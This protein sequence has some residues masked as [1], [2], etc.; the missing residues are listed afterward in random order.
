MRLI[1]I[2][3]SPAILLVW[4][5]YVRGRPSQPLPRRLVA[6]LFVLGGLSAGL[7]LVLNHLVEKYTLFWSG[8]PEFAHRLG[9]WFLGIG[10]N[11]ELAKMIVLLAVLYPRRLFHAPY[12]GLLGAAAVA[13]G[14]AA[15]EN[16]VY[17]DRYGTVTL[18]F[19]S[20]LTVPA[21]AFFS[22]PMGVMLAYAKRS[23]NAAGQY[24]WLLGALTV[25]AAL[26]GGYDLWLSFESDWINRLAY[27]QVLLMAALAWR[28]MRLEPFRPG[29]AVEGLR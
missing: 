23:R 16:V 7:A 27:L 21:H 19:R 14:F 22:I 12:Q 29:P 24:A 17:L 25:A 9:F 20:L 10:L 28:L 6:V 5:L 13:L 11:E 4:F 15:V 1:A 3:L 26:H 8:A 18:L 2:A